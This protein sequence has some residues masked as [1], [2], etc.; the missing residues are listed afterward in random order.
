L[1]C[2]EIQPGDGLLVV[3]VSTGD[4]GEGGRISVARAD[5]KCHS[6]ERVIRGKAGVNRIKASQRV[7]YSVYLIRVNKRRKP[8]EDGRGNGSKA[9]SHPRI[10]KGT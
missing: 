6:G 9:R 7:W 4:R 8:T 3:W 5:Y 1:D 2:L 10:S